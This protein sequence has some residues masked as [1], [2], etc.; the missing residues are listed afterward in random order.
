MES[1]YTDRRITCM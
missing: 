1:F